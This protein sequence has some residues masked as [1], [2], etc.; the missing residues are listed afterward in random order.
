M[1]QK[2]ASYF[3]SFFYFQFSWFAFIYIFNFL[4][5]Y[6]FASY[7]YLSKVLVELIFMLTFNQF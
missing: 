3:H 5:F 7:E 1:A 6:Y 2:L 4:T